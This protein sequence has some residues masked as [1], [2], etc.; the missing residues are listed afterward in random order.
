M[1]F[2]EIQQ[3]YERINRLVSDATNGNIRNAIQKSDLEEA[4][5]ILLSALFFQGQWTVNERFVCNL[6]LYKTRYSP[7]M[8]PF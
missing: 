1:N 6:C 7:F 3:S 4:R 2:A 8:L 5:L